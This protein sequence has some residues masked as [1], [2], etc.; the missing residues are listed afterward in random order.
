MKKTGIALIY[1]AR[2]IGWIFGS[3]AVS[4]AVIAWAIAAPFATAGIALMGE[5]I[6]LNFAGLKEMAA[7]IWENFE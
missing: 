1:L 7:D 6:S 3:I 2:I 4:S 5:P